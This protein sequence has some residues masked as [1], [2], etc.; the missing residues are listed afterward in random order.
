[1]ALLDK[2]EEE[3]APGDYDA[4]HDQEEGHP[5]YADLVHQPSAEEAN[6]KKPHKDFHGLLLWHQG[7]DPVWHVD[8]NLIQH[9]AE[10]SQ[11]FHIVQ[12]LLYAGRRCG[13][14]MGYDN[15]CIC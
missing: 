13:T 12:C 9:D 11:A 5:F 10:H 8:R 15:A 7:A 1:M 14:L 4:Q 2:A 3:V 6:Q